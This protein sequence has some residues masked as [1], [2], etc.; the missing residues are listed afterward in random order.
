M[1]FSDQL[2][3]QRLRR[4]EE[5]SKLQDS[6]SDV[7]LRLLESVVVNAN[8]GV[9]I[10]EAD[11]I[12]DLGPR[13]QYVNPAFTR[14]SGYR[15]EE[16]LGKTP[17]IMQ[18]PE[19]DKEALLKIKCALRERRTIE[20]ELLNYR[21]DG[22]TFWVA[23]SISPVFD[24]F[25]SLKNW[26]AVLRDISERKANEEM[27]VRARL[28]ELQNEQLAAEIAVRKKVET[29]LA[30]AA[31]HDSLT[32]LKNRDYFLERL[33]ETLQRTRTRQSYRS[34]LVYLDLDGFKTI[35][36]GLGHRLG[37][38]VLVEIARRL[39]R[40]CRPQDTLCR[41]GGDEF[42]LLLD[43]VQTIEQAS[44]ITQRIL[45]ELNHP[46]K[47]GSGEMVVSASL[48]LCEMEPRYEQAEDVLRDADI[49]MY[50]A[51]QQGGSRYVAFSEEMHAKALTT[52]QVKL[53]LK[54][55]VQH[56]DF[57]LYYQPLVETDTKRIV[58]V[59]ALV[60]WRHPERG[61]LLPSEF[62][63][64]A[65]E[66]GLIVPLG[67][68]ILR[69]ACRQLRTW[70]DSFT[71]MEL[72]LSVNVSC[73]Q[74]ED[75]SFF[76]NLVEIIAETEIDCRWLQIEVTETVLLRDAERMGALFEQMRAMGVRIALDDFGTGYSS[77][78]Y[79]ERYP[80]DTLKIDKS[81]VHRLEAGSS[82]A[83]IVKMIIDLA[84]GLGLQVSAE[85]V[86]KLHQVE[87][88]REFGCTLAQ[89]NLYRPPVSMEEM[90]ILLNNRF[91]QSD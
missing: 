81:F 91:L 13:I 16:V 70:L 84:R 26:I 83:D 30:H 54:H 14:L 23:V 21:K 69:H 8:D 22:S 77:L 9:M 66:T 40:C 41:Y 78:S 74:L 56:K 27:V 58:G 32:G 87:A 33:K 45:E 19:T 88:L 59:E 50:R 89:G 71:G 64:L 25:R 28:A 42:T 10:T 7:H 90:T 51:K 61:L 65:E 34:F 82:K 18:G 75:A 47:A 17:R 39:E 2:K 79:L 63:S 57:V 36:D 53:Q 46:L 62:V 52:L 24:E 4:F 20:V 37:D 60:R 31:F 5:E 86:E 48:G 43:E 55:A 35:N 80:I 11:P 38:L 85:G 15:P 29:Q 67:A 72:T 76:S 49:A 68:W 1:K 3:L 44:T 6:A 12:E 73:K